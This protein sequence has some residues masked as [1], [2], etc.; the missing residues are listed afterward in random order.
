VV[1]KAG[2]VGKSQVKEFRVVFLGEVQDRF[3]ISH[4]TLLAPRRAHLGHD[5]HMAE[6]ILY[7]KNFGT[8]RYDIASAISGY[9][10]ESIRGN[11][12]FL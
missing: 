2:Q 1:P 5:L 10:T 11:R 7:G 4:E 12:M 3:S 9:G 8:S 6:K